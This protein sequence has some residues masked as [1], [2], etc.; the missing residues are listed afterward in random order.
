VPFFYPY[1]WPSRVCQPQPNG[2]QQIR[3]SAR[4]LGRA[5]AVVFLAVS[6]TCATCTR[7]FRPHLIPG[8]W[9]SPPHQTNHQAPPSRK[10]H[11]LPT[12]LRGTAAAA[13]ISIAAGAAASWASPDQ[14]P[15]LGRHPPQIMCLLSRLRTCRA[16]CCVFH[17]HWCLIWPCHL[18]C[19]PWPSRVCSPMSSQTPA[20]SGISP[21]DTV[22]RCCRSSLIQHPRR[23]ALS[24]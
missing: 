8:L 7:P 10:Q 22:A 24:Y 23:M 11:Q 5:A 21:F 17:P 6:I 16:R 1:T 12:H 9:L 14:T 2:H 19:H 18:F 4:D 20:K 15:D 13:L 3:A